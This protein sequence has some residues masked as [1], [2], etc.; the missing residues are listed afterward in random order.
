MSY[1]KNPWQ[2]CIQ[3]QLIFQPCYYP[4]FDSLLLYHSQFE[5]CL[6]MQLYTQNRNASLERLF[7]V[8]GGYALNSYLSPTHIP[9]MESIEHSAKCI[10][11]IFPFYVFFVFHCKS[12]VSLPFISSYHSIS[13]PFHFSLLLFLW[14]KNTSD[15]KQI[16]TAATLDLS[17][18]A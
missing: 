10:L 1:N 2:F 8:G 3:P 18:K 12:L 6:T 16:R 17:Q 11:K 13:L 9:N 5:L 14:I 7:L 15:I 4:T